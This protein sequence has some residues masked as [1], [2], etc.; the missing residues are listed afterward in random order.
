MPFTITLPAVNGSSDVQIANVTTQPFTLTHPNITFHITGTVLP[1]PRNVSGAVSAFLGNYV[2]ARDSDIILS[3]PLFPGLTVPAKFP[4]PRP[5]PT[6]LRNVTI[7]DMKIKPVGAGMVASG[8]VLARVV[9]PRG[10]EVGVDVVRVFPDVIV[11]DGPVPEEL[12]AALKT[13]FRILNYPVNDDD[14]NVPPCA[15]LARP[16]P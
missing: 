13:D 7:R 11:Y 15:V 16:A 6:I 3:T 8:T 1:L 4:A 2:S 12:H 10:I 5:K 14:R 9:L